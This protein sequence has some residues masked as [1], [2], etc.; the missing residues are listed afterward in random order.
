VKRSAKSTR[1]HHGC[2]GLFFCVI[3]FF[4]A[5]AFQYQTLQQQQKQSRYS[6]SSNGAN[7]LLVGQLYQDFILH[8]DEF[9]SEDA[10][11]RASKLEIRSGGNCGNTLKVLSQLPNVQT[12]CMTSLG[13][14]EEAG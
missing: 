6:M 9:P 14:K 7:V 5:S 3:F 13:P 11:K 2:G 10:K 12:W 1:L 8:V 4:A